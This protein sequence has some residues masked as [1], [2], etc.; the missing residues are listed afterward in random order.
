MKFEVNHSL[1]KFTYA[2]QSRIQA[3][4]DYAGIGQHTTDDDQVVQ[5]RTGHFYVAL[6]P[7]FYVEG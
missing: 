2:G 5:L 6:V 1:V 4:E 7:V 3:Q